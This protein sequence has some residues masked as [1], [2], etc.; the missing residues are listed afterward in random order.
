MSPHDRE[1]DVLIRARYPILYIV[2]PEEE[3]V[4]DA[5][6]RIVDGRKLVQS[7]SASEPFVPADLS[8]A[9]PGVLDGTPAA[10]EALQYVERRVREDNARGV[11]ACCAISIHISNIRWWRD[12]CAI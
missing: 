2:S 1:I 7:W 10:I 5:L 11:F 8:G 3:R 12:G 9:A 4:E 6:R